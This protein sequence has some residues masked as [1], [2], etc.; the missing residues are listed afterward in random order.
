MAANNSSYK[1][2]FIH[3]IFLLKVGGEVEG[4][5]FH[6]LSTEKTIPRRKL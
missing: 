3:N 2:L 5:A 4:I 6:M 1:K